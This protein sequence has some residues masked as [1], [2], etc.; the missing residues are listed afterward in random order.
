[1]LRNGFS[2]FVC[3]LFNL[4]NV[5]QK[6]NMKGKLKIHLLIKPTNFF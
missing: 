2:L 4:L 5:V 6:I 3:M 1:M